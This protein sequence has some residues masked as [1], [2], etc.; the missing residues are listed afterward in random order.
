MKLEF[1]IHAIKRMFE[2][3]IIESDV[4]HVL[5]TGTVIEA[6]PEDTPYP[7]RLIFGEVKGRALHVVVADDVE[8][9]TVI[10]ITVYEPDVARWGSDFKRRKNR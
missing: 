10:V 9:A 1:R 8:H 4:R 5:R 3:R 6:Y 2:R 7:S